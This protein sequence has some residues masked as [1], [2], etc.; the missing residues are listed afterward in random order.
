[1]EDFKKESS[2]RLRVINYLINELEDFH[3][4]FEQFLT[5]DNFTE[6]EITRFSK[7]TF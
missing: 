3:N 1:M 6:E 5:T 7:H 4:A 2:A